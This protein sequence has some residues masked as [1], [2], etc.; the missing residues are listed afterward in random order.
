MS[1]NI[2]IHWFGER[3][4]QL[5]PQLQALHSNGGVLS[6]VVQIELGRG[7]AGWVGRRLAR[8]LGV[9]TDLPQ[10][11][12][13]VEIQHAK[14]GLHWHRYFAGGQTMRSLFQPVGTWPT[15]YWRED[16]GQL[17]L[18]L[19]VDIID[20]GWYWRT[21]SMRVMGIQMPLWLFPKLQAYKRI[22]AGQYRF[23]VEARLPLLGKV[24]RYHGL[25]SVAP[26]TN[27]AKE[28]T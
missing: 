18:R 8:K 17:H 4:Q 6:G 15:G 24:L 27:A 26:S 28:C 12:F 25:L 22:E 20:G 9:P 21:L 1:D 23:S 2:V 19:T 10:R 3:F 16:T 14:D 13:R 5:H 7:L 11:D